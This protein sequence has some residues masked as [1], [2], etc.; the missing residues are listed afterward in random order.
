MNPYPIENLWEKGHYTARLTGPDPK[1]GAGRE[2]L[3]GTPNKTRGVILTGPTDI[4]EL[5]AWI[6]RA[7]GKK[8]HG[9]GRPDPE[10]TELIA[11]MEHAWQVVAES[12]TTD[13]M[14]AV[15]DTG[16]PRDPAAQLADACRKIAAD[17]DAQREKIAAGRIDHDNPDPY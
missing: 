14:V 16:P 9:C 11:A 3:R 1:Y 4:G 2:F 13:L 17:D 12:P 5:P 15:W 6:I 8:C 10:S 7:G